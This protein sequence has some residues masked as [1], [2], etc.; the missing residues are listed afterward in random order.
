MFTVGVVWENADATLSEIETMLNMISWQVRHYDV[1][2]S[3]ED[4][5]Q[6]YLQPRRNQEP[7]TQKEIYTV[8]ITRN[9]MLLWK[10]LHC[11]FLQF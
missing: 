10:A 6:Q 11:L 2:D 4:R 8:Q 9:D 1:V 7:K 3:L 5:S